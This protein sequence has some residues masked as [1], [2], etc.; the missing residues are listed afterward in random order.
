[1]GRLRAGD[2]SWL[3]IEDYLIRKAGLDRTTLMALQTRLLQ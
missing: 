1:M 3:S 2:D